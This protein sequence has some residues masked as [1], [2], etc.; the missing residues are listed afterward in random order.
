MTKTE[1]LAIAND[2]NITP[3]EFTCE[4]KVW[5]G[6]ASARFP[7]FAPGQTGYSP[8]PCDGCFRPDL[9]DSAIAVQVTRPT[10]NGPRPNHLIMD[11]C[12]NHPLI[13]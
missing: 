13:T 7:T 5:G 4:W 11:H 8:H 2:P 1:A 6:P 9:V 10:W 12:Q 3:Q